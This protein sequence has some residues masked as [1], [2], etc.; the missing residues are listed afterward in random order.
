VPVNSAGE[1]IVGDNDDPAAA[2]AGASVSFA[3]PKSS[4]LIELLPVMLM[5]AGFRSRWMTPCA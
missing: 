3:R 4:T 2:A 5:F 1:V